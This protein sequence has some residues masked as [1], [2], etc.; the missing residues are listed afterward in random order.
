MDFKKIK[1]EYGQYIAFQGGI[2][3][4]DTMP[5]GTVAEV[6]AEV[7]R[8]IDTLGPAGG[9]ILCTSHN[10]QP[11]TPLENILAMYETAL[12]VGQYP[13]ST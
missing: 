7:K 1:S 3:I 13:L 2:D 9:Y 12:E 8:A 6:K 10:I 4:Q 11:D 5:F